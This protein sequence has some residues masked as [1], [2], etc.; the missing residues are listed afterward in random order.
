MKLEH[1]MTEPLKVYNYFLKEE[2]HLAAEAYFDGLVLKNG[3]DAEYNR[4]L[5]RDLTKA[6]AA[7]DK[8]NGKLNLRRA[9]RT[10]AIIATIIC[11]IAALII[12]I[13]SIFNWA[14]AWWIIFIALAPIA[15]GVGLIFLIVKVINK[16]IKALQ[17]RLSK[18]QAKAD[19]ILQEARNQMEPLNS[20]YDWNA[21]AKIFDDAFSLVKF[22][23]YFDQNKFYYLRDKYGFKENEDNI[24]SIYVQSGSILGNPFIVERNRVREIRDHVYTGTL[25]IHWT[26]V[27]GSGKNR[28]VHHHTQTLTASVTKPRPE[29]FTETWLVYGNEAAPRL[30]FSRNP[31]P[32]SS[33]DEKRLKKYVEN[34]EKEFDKKIKNAK[35]GAKV[36][37]MMSNTEFEALF[38]ASNRDNDVE[39][40]LLFT[41]LAQKNLIDLVKHSPFGDDFHFI[42]NKELN[43]IMSNHMQN[44]DIDT[45]PEVFRNYD[46]DKARKYFVDYV[47][48]YFAAFYFDLAPLMS[49]PLYQ[50]HQSFEEIFKGTLDPNVT[51]FESEMIA[52]HFDQSLFRHP[53]SDTEAIL[54]RTVVKKNGS[55][56]DL[57]LVHA[58]SYKAIPHT[59]FITKMGGDGLPHQVP[60][61][62]YEYIELEQV[63][64]LA[65]QSCQASEKK[66]RNGIQNQ[67][68][69]DFLSRLDKRGIII[70]QR[71]L[72]SFFLN[73][74]NNGYNEDELDNYIQE[75]N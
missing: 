72:I 57:V 23:Q 29:Y 49:I 64:P 28:V 21:P 54:K 4:Q 11:F 66:F 67:A 61:T 26:T 3:V 14:D 44:A 62:W 70:Y 39:F 36:Q 37:T 74:A 17:E 15:V 60:V 42:K 43:Y 48:K 27:T 10:L 12:I 18:L 38:G 59:D 33:Y 19:E 25:T 20:D 40:R 63:T 1:D 41:P 24:S 73:N 22:D 31:C 65:V 50:M 2:V 9:L 53:D 34:F 75:E 52:N 71:G 45:D 8:F 32:A 68:L 56:G 55:K 35:P 30:S 5:M 13:A 6:R 47:D 46:H 16:K 7:I 58:H 69:R 51:S